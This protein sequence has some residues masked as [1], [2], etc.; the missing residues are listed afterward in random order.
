MYHDEFTRTPAR[1]VETYGN[2][3]LP[4]VALEVGGGLS[5]GLAASLNQPASMLLL[6]VGGLL[7]LLAC[8]TSIVAHRCSEVMATLAPLFR[9]GRPSAVPMPHLFAAARPSRRLQGAGSVR[10]ASPDRGRLDPPAR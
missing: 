9:A 7:P 2:D 5:L 1:K 8:C 10:G 6:Y 4:S 3:A